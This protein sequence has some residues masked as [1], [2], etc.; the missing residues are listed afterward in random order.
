MYDIMKLED[1]SR[2]QNRPT[3]KDTLKELNLPILKQIL[4]CKE[5]DK[6]LN[7]FILTLPEEVD[8]VDNK[9]HC[10]FNQYGAKTG[11]QSCSNPNLTQIPSHN[12]E[13]RMMFKASVEE[14]TITSTD[15]VYVVP[16]TDEVEVEKDVWKSVK[17]LIIGNT[18]INNCNQYEVI[19]DIKIVDKNYY[20]YVE[21]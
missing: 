16:Y 4:I 7:S 18:I 15:N 14:H 13:I 2:E 3:D 8:K 12:K 10:S 5:Y 1:K 6:L 11:R 21:D 17:D 20:I 9:I 19:K